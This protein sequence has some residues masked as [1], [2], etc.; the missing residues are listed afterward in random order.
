MF[1]V[2]VNVMNLFL[3]EMGWHK[4]HGNSHIINEDPVEIMREETDDR[5]YFDASEGH[6]GGVRNIFFCKNWSHND[7]AKKYVETLF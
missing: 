1:N 6:T 2:H 7:L 4:N 3:V 5:D